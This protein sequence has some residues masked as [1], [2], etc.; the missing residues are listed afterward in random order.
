MTP[1]EAPVWG[2]LLARAGDI[3]G[4]CSLH[5]AAAPDAARPS[6]RGR[7][8]RRRLVRSSDHGGNGH[9]CGIAGFLAKRD[10]IDVAARLTAMLQAM[11]GR[12]PDSTGVSLYGSPHPGDLV[13]SIWAGDDGGLSAR[14]PVLRAIERH[15]RVLDERY[16]E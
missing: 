3:R 13:A 4:V 14:E 1:R 2:C 12:G 15:G 6:R 10:G 9:M 7:R 8:R 5:T 11:R 16:S